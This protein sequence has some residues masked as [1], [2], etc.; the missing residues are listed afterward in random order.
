[1][2]D[3]NSYHELEEWLKAM[4]KKSR[5]AEL[6][7]QNLINPVLLILL[8]LR[9][10]RE[11]EFALHLYVCKQMMPYFFAAGHVNYA[12]YGLCYLRTMER[13]TGK[14]L[15]Q[16]LSGKHVMHNISGLFNGIWFDM[17]IETTYMK[18]GKCP[19]GIIGMT[20]KPRTLEIWAKKSTC[21]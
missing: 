1:M 21:R 11:G 6:W 3:I 13:L 10:E 9:A 5:L 15:E 19:S 20:T 14:V 8:Y 2:D 4:R 12:R 7:I 16:F 17:A 18:H